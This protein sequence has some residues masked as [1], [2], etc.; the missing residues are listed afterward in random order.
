MLFKK[1]KGE[2]IILLAPLFIVLILFLF[3]PFLSVI[4]ESFYDSSGNISF[5]NYKNIFQ[6]AYI[7]ALK[8]VFSFL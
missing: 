2:E 7:E 4:K 6:K 8:I 1:E 5:I 3:V